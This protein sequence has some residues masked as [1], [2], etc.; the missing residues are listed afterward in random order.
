MPKILSNT[1]RTIIFALLKSHVYRGDIKRP[2]DV[3]NYYYYY[4]RAYLKMGTF[5]A[6]H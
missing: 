5:Y 3:V 4:K 1:E 2:D 6:E